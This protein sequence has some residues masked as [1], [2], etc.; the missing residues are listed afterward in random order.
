MYFTWKLT[1]EVTM[2]PNSEFFL[3]TLTVREASL[4]TSN[5]CCVPL[6]PPSQEQ[7]QGQSQRPA[8]R[9]PWPPLQGTGLTGLLCWAH[10]SINHLPVGLGA[11]WRELTIY[12]AGQVVEALPV[13]WRSACSLTTSNQG[14]T[15]RKFSVSDT[16]ITMSEYTGGRESWCE[17]QVG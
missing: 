9:D 16:V 14:L 13:S 8:D 2:S 5:S 11:R 4:P 1:E 17:G 10:D 15:N 6:S 3:R 7:D 12:R